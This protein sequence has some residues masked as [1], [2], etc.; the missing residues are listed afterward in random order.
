M[1]RCALSCGR[2]FNAGPDALSHAP[3]FH[4]DDSCGPHDEGDREAAKSNI[5]EAGNV[6][7]ASLVFS[8]KVAGM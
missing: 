6:R 8:I 1:F 2:S 7:R 4:C 3:V 5:S